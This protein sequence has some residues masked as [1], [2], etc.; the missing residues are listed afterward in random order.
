[1]QQEDAAAALAADD[2]FERALL[3]L[4]ERLDQDLALGREHQLVVSLVVVLD[5]VHMVDCEFAPLLA[6][7]GEALDGGPAAVEQ[8]VRHVREAVLVLVFVVLAAAAL[9]VRVHLGERFFVEHAAADCFVHDGRTPGLEVHVVGLGGVVRPHA[10]LHELL[11][12]LGQVFLGL[13]ALREQFDA[14]VVEFFGVFEL[15]DARRGAGLVE[16]LAAGFDDLD[17]DFEERG[18]PA[19]LVVAL[20]DFAAD[21]AGAVAVAEARLLV[22]AEVQVQLVERNFVFAL[23][24]LLVSEVRAEFLEQERDQLLEAFDLGVLALELR[25]LFLGWLL[26]LHSVFLRF[27]LRAGLFRGVGFS[28]AWLRFWFGVR[29]LLAM[30]MIIGGLGLGFSLGRVFGFLFGLGLRLGLRPEHTLFEQVHVFEQRD[31]PELHVVALEDVESGQAAQLGL[32]CRRALLFAADDHH[33]LPARD[34]PAVTRVF[35]DDLVHLDQRFFGHGFFLRFVLLL[36]LFLLFLLPALFVVVLF[37]SFVL[38]A[39]VFALDVVLALFFDRELQYQ[40]RHSSHCAGLRA[41]G[42]ENR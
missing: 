32:E 40:I 26:L 6:G 42:Q 30:T 7:E 22:D 14:Q 11:A 17:R 4:H 21:H 36:L 18:A 28:L 29:F 41:F 35:L 8:V 25:V 15:V 19:A 2:V 9:V 39:F 1:V 31:R 27:A 3:V 24:L 12:A 10:L 34:S 23:Q 38:A 37:C 13:R 16:H 33:F 20:G 5:F